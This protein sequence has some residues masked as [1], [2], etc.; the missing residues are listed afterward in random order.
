MLQGR[1]LLHPFV[2]G[3]LSA[4]VHHCRSLACLA[5][6]IEIVSIASHD[7]NTCMSV[8]WRLPGTVDQP[9]LLALPHQLSHH[10][11][12]Q[13]STAEDHVYFRST[14]F[15]ILQIVIQDHLNFTFENLARFL[16]GGRVLVADLDHYQPMHTAPDDQGEV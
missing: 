10:R 2:V 4:L 1:E 6:E 14:H 9:H 16:D 8:H 3:W 5:G 13:R 12:T 11:L 7:L 15:L